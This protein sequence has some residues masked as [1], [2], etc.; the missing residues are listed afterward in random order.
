MGR[1]RFITLVVGLRSL[2][3]GVPQPQ[4]SPASLPVGVLV[5]GRSVVAQ[6]PSGRCACLS[7]FLRVTSG[8]A[9]QPTGLPFP[10]G[11]VDILRVALGFAQWPTGPP[12]PSVILPCLRSLYRW[13][14]GLVRL[15]A[16][17][18]GSFFLLTLFSIADEK[19]KTPLNI[20]A[21]VSSFQAAL[22]A[23]ACHAQPCPGRGGHPIQGENGAALIGR[24]AYAAG[25]RIG[26]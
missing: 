13:P 19:P 16:L 21:H 15:V 6:L 8:F 20:R 2:T 4:S 11:T 17:P 10:F 12:L 25:G 9:G 23:Q 14:C 1:P 7:P 22:A 3:A 26:I 5:T 18:M 24:A